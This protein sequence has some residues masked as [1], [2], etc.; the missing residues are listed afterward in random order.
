VH[1][2]AREIRSQGNDNPA[3]DGIMAHDKQ[4]TIVM[5][6]AKALG[7]WFV[8]KYV[9]PISYAGLRRLAS[10]HF[11]PLHTDVWLPNSVKAI[12]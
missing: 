4:M 8:L 2:E 9:N 6:T 5:E 10:V 7:K 1:R 3:I 11:R 12:K